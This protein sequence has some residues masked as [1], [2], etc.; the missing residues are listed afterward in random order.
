[1]SMFES[2]APLLDTAGGQDIIQ[3]QPPFGG[4]TH[5][6]EGYDLHLTLI[7]LPALEAYASRVRH[8]VKSREWGNDHDGLSFKIEKVAWVKESRERM[9]ERSGAARKKRLSALDMAPKERKALPPVKSWKAAKPSPGK[10]VVAATA[11]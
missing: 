2:E 1:M 4:P 6:P 8:G 9:E 5:A 7:I 10:D 11:A 3:D